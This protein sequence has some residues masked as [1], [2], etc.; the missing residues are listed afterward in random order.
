MPI[1]APTEPVNENVAV[2]VV[3]ETNVRPVGADS[4]VVAVKSGDTTVPAEFIALMLNV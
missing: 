3:L 4:T 1:V 2:F